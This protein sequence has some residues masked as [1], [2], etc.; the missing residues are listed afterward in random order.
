MASI[1]P[2]LHMARQAQAKPTPW[3]VETATARMD[4]IFQMSQVTGGYTF[5]CYALPD[6][7]EIQSQQLDTEGKSSACVEAIDQP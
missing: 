4:R 5:A 3:R 2:S 6:C 7:I 1:A